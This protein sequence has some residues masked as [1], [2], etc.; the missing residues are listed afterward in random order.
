M[1]ETTRKAVEQVLAN[2]GAGFKTANEFRSYM[3]W[4]ANDLD[5]SKFVETAKDVRTAAQVINALIYA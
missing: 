2:H 5:D 4:L 1:L 3:L